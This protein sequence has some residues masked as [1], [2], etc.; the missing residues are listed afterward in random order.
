VLAKI[1]AAGLDLTEVVINNS[2]NRVSHVRKGGRR[3]SFNALVVVGDRKGHVGVGMGKAG[4]VAE[5]IR[6]G[7]ENAKKQMVRVPVIDGTIP[8]EIVGE[9]G[10]ARVLL[11]PAAPGT[12]VIAGGGT[13][14]VLEL[15]G[16][17]NV[18]SKSLGSKNP[19][20]TVK[21][22]LNGLLSLKD[23]R[24]FAEL[25]GVDPA[26]LMKAAS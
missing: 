5:A 25:R 20:N 3:F 24:A 14:A 23:A 12:G 9:F 6:K 26:D 13:R 15:A 4:E 19:H 10:A 22:V 16:I 17:N 21:A 11:K 18:L 7:S 8:H 2:I 1:D